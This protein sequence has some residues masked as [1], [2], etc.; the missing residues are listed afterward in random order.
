MLRSSAHACAPYGA[1][2][3][4]FDIVKPSSLQDMMSGKQLPTLKAFNQTEPALQSD[5]RA[6]MTDQADAGQ[7][8][9]SW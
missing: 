1:L 6:C 2:G 7:Q 5:L 4:A 9:H 3:A 8:Q